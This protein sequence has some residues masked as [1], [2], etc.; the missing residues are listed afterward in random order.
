MLE[1]KFKIAFLLAILAFAALP[2]MGILRGTTST[3][4][5]DAPSQPS[6]DVSSR[7]AVPSDEA[8][9]K[10]EMVHIP[11]GPFLRGTD[12]GGFDEKPPREIYLDA[13]EIDKYEVTNHLYGQFA[14][15]TGH[16]KAGPPSRYAKN[17]G[18]MRGTNQP[19]VYISWEDAQEYC[20]WKGK[21]LPTEAEW[22][23]AM[24]GTDGRLWPWGSLEQPNGANWARINDGYEATAPVGTF[25]TDSS[26]Y[27]VMDGAGNVME[28]V[29]DWYAE[30]YYRE[31]T[32]KNPPS[33][34]HGVYRVL[35]GGGYTTTGGDL[36]ITSRSKMV[37][38]FRDETIG[39]RCARTTE[40]MA[41]GTS[42]GSVKAIGNQ[43]SKGSETRPK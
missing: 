23:K 8:P 35:R 32:D 2:I 28:W 25:K 3:P 18:K 42:T 1:T 30:A 12:A 19:V 29:E 21:R 9:V 43:S 33:P 27:G 20:R 31:S 40:I 16:R 26:P 17:V 37:P 34:E 10:E 11:A 24:R 4:F 22:E 14:A 5:E 41:P 13:F 6:E 39:F 15:A 7:P 38:D 36:R